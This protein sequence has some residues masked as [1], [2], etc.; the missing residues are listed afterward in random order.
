MNRTPLRR[1]SLNFMPGFYHKHLGLT[2]GEDYYFDPHHRARVECAENRF[3]F[4]ILGRYEVGSPTPKP[5]P[6]LFI[7]PIDLIKIT[8]GAE[9]HCPPDAT[10]ETRGSPWAGLTPG[11]IDTLSPADAAR[12]PFLDRLLRHYRELQALYGDQ[13]DLFGITAGRLNI[14]TPFTTAHQLCGEDLFPLMLDDPEAAR[15]IFAKVW[16]LYEAL[17]DRL[18]RALHARPPRHVQLGDCSACLLSEATYRSVVLPVN[19]AIAA[20]FGEGG[21][22][23]CG[24]SSH[25]L[26]AFAAIPG[27][28]A[29][30]LGPGTD[31]ET[32]TRTLPGVALRPLIDPIL[33]RNGRRG[34][35]ETAIRDMLSATAAAPETTLCAWSFDTETPV[36]NVETLYATATAWTA[37]ESCQRR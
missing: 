15:R 29:I 34:E 21:Y 14:H 9:L 31:L 25:L 24:A 7:Q 22:H 26:T 12:H 10:L 1:I 13:A 30:E 19:R 23:S 16:A 18:T 17:F 6:S 8:Q 5:S 36:P 27:I 28:T 4:E 35:I 20:R 2:Y 32:A 33:M 37:D 11:Q 3:L